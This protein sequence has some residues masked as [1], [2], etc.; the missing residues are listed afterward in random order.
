MKNCQECQ[1]ITSSNCGNHNLLYVL[2]LPLVIMP[3]N[4]LCCIAWGTRCACERKG[5][6][7]IWCKPNCPCCQS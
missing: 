4:C 1:K 3:V 6:G 5:L 2:N 7:K